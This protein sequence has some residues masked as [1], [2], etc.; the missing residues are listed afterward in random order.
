VAHDGEEKEHLENVDQDKHG[1]E[2][3][4]AGERQVG[5]DAEEGIGQERNPEHAGGQKEAGLELAVFGV[6]EG[7]GE[8]EGDRADDN[9]EKQDQRDLF[10]RMHVRDSG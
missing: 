8:G 9:K 4:E 2:D 3:I 1:E 10:A 6:E 5:E 7:E